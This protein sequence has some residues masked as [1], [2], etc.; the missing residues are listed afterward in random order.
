MQS[1]W[2]LLACVM[3]AMMGAFV[4][5]AADLGASLPE[6]V[7]FR[8]VP[9][10]LLLFFWARSTHR[11]IR[12]TSWRLHIWRNLSGITSMWLGFYALFGLPLPTATS[13]NYTAPLFIAGWLLLAG[14]AQR[15][16]VRILAVA[17][18]FL[19]VLGILRPSIAH[20]EWFFAVMG[21]GAGAF[22]AVA[23]MQIRQLGQI[24]EPEWLTVLLFSCGVVI[25]SLVGLSI[26]GWHTRN[27][28]ALLALTGLGSAGLVGQLAMTRAFGLGSTLLTAALQYTTIIFAA[29]IGI[30]FWGDRLAALAWAGIVLIIG[31]G[32]LSI[33]RTYS[34]NRLLRGAPADTPPVLSR[35]AQEDPPS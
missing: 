1:L 8:G 13:L 2:M 14:G 12:P 23:M 15:D 9:S 11:A 22:A 24:G 27:P 32:L 34:E 10:V 16:P 5:V 35:A 7:L 30:V 19:G 33:W 18:G 26:V 28:L 17:A 31:S 21:L 25:S 20:D 29:L 3:F 6:I 4:K